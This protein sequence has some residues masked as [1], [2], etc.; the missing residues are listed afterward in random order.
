MAP[1]Y[2]ATRMWFRCRRGALSFAG[3][4]VVSVKLRSLEIE[5]KGCRSAGEK[6]VAAP[7]VV[8][9]KFCWAGKL[10][11]ES[12]GCCRASEKDIAGQGNRG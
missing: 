8:S 4:G 3:P 5:S 1:L 11:I 6:D 2:A 7:G 9:V 10:R 12:K